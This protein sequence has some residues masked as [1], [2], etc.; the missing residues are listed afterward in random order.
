ML[1]DILKFKD[2]IKKCNVDIFFRNFI[3][4][5][6]FISKNLFGIFEDYWMDYYEEC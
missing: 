3:M 5:C 4:E 2:L 1:G 6:K